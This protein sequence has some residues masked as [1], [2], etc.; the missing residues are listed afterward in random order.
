M[1]TPVFVPYKDNVVVVNDSDKYCLLYKQY[2]KIETYFTGIM[3]NGNKG[4]LTMLFHE[5]YDY[6]KVFNRAEAFA[7][8][9]I[10]NSKDTDIFCKFAKLRTME[11]M[12]GGN[13]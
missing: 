4:R 3:F 13:S 7:A 6:A 2:G 8:A 9:V 5:K 12:K 1:A 11:E 10:A